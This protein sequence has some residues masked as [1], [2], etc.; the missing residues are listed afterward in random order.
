MFILFIAALAVGINVYV[1][2]S[3][4]DEIAASIDSH[5]DA[6]TLEEKENLEAFNAD[7]ILVLGASVKPDG[8]PSH[9]LADRLDVGIALYKEGFAPKLLLSGDD[10]QV[11]Y[12]E[13]EVM[14]NYAVAAGVPQEDIFL[15]HAG[16][17]TYESVYRAKYV[18]KVE[19]VIAVTQKYHLYRTLHGCRM[20]GI[21]AVGA[22]SD[23]DVYSGQEY[24]E[25]REILA[26]VKDFVKWFI[27]PEP[28]FL[29]DEIPV[30]GNGIETH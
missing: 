2:K 16:F 20:M 17:S 28:T 8:T 13:V 19:R 15:D 1:V 4:E 18:F 14:K 25:V 11:E 24:R 9:M 6:V 10:G 21:E 3:T 5:V 22:A 23:Q 7:C 29:G 30:S 27:K 26:R 12:N